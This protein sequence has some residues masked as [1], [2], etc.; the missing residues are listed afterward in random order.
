MPEGKLAGWAL[1]AVV[2]F[3]PLLL[4]AQS[5]DGPILRPHKSVP[6]AAATATLL[7]MCDLSC[8]W[9]LDGEPKGRIEA[10][11]SGKSKAGFGQHVVI[12]TTE[13]GLDRVL[14]ISEARSSGQTVVIVELKPIRSARLATQEKA[15]QDADAKAKENPRLEPERLRPQQKEGILDD[16]WTDPDT[17]LMWTKRDNGQNVDW[18]Q[19]AEYCKDLRLGGYTSWRLPEI[20]ELRG[21]Y[22]SRRSEQDWEKVSTSQFPYHVKG[23]IQ[24]SAGWHW[25]TLG[26][27]AGKAWNL[28]F[29]FGK[30]DF[31]T[32]D[33]STNLR[34]LCVRPSRE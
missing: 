13:D 10:G 2:A 31:E 1:A 8:N 29:R 16:T 22:D 17:E 27:V 9:S 28:D 14:Q 6:P 34:A 18:N 23:Q 7:V 4:L 26:G 24:L 11:A 32:L 21:I 19:A 30:A 12:A 25:S 3:T 15:T 33:V 5:D 20:D